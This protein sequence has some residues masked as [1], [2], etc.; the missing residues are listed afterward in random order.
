MSE[1]ALGSETAVL[2][3]A[4]QA[5]R[6]MEVG[7]LRLPVC[8]PRRVVPLEVGIGRVHR[9][10]GVVGGAGHGHHP[11]RRGGEQRGH[12]SRGEHPVTEMIDPELHLKSIGGTALGHRHESGVVH[13]NVDLRM[14]LA[15]RGGGR[16][17]RVER[18]EI[19]RHDLQRCRRMLAG[20]LFMRSR[21]LLLTPRRHHDMRAC[22]GQ[23]LRRFEPESP[24]GPGDHGHLAGQIGNVLDRP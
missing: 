4:L 7:Q 15:D 2:E 6:E 23:R 21:C 11:G 20:D 17:H 12:E 3:L 18:G 8:L 14:V 16:P 13:E 22:P 19:D 1:E 10:A 5:E 24:V 9:L